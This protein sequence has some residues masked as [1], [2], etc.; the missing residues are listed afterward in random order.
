ML[1]QKVLAASSFTT[2]KKHF[3]EKKTKVKEH[4]GLMK[5]N[6]LPGFWSTALVEGA[7]LYSF[8]NLL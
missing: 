2:R 3:G 4:K 1:F 7:H 8:S 5:T 6:C